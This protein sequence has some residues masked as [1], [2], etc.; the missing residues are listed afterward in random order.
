MKIIQLI[1][2]TFLP[3]VLLAVDLPFVNKTL[4]VDVREQQFLMINLTIG[5]PV[6]TIPVAVSPVATDDQP[7]GYSDLVILGVQNKAGSFRWNDSKTFKKSEISYDFYKPHGPAGWIVSDTVGLGSLQ[8][9]RNQNFRVF[10]N[11]TGNFS[12]L[13][14]NLPTNGNP[15]AFI[16]DVLKKEKEQVIAFSF[17]SISPSGY[18]GIMS[19]GDRAPKRCAN[20]WIIIDEVPGNLQWMIEVEEVTT[21]KYS[22]EIAGKLPVLIGVNDD[23]MVLPKD[24]AAEICSD[25]GGQF[26][27]YDDYFQVSCY[28]TANISF[29]SPM[30]VDFVL[31]PDDYLDTSY[32]HD[33]CYLKVMKGPEKSARLPNAVL[34][35][36][37]LLLDYANFQVGLASRIKN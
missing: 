3:G 25:L 32:G 6:Q 18:S 16:R 8:L 10:L 30:G 7:A 14:L 11:S 12:T 29:K 27:T 24:L 4:I 31:T 20:D 37:C 28:Q 17:D 33:H 22:R 1:V 26:C 21:G 19:I 13:H 36:K 34:R 15:S 9:N 5:T 35:D 23:Y 2:Y